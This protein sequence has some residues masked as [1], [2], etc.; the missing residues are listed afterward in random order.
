MPELPEV[1]TIVNALRP[2]AVGRTFAGVRVNDV[3]PLQNLSPEEFCQK[4]IGR[5][6][7]ALDRRGKY[8][9]FRLSGGMNM[10]V[11]L[12]MT[13]ALLWNPAASEPFSRVEYFFD[14]GSLLVF[15]DIRRF[16]TIF[17]VRDASKV[18]G[19][20]GIEPLGNDF[21]A[22]VLKKLLDSRSAPVKSVLLNQEQIA[23]I[24][25]MYADEALFKAKIHPARPASSLHD[26]ELG[27][28]HD[29]IRDVLRRG[30]KNRGASIRDYRAPDGARG[31]AHTEFCVAHRLGEKC[32]RCGTPIKRVVVG[33][34]GTY[35]CP[36][37]QPLRRQHV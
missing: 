13:G 24:G 33:Q 3:R 30:V 5:K 7:I 19:K 18:V 17:L 29:A 16:G 4:L 12:R 6:I 15:S 31:S 9:I 2:H 10:I 20:L 28:L 1:E 22:A 34:R 32:P 11:H 14:D 25:N 21:T 26:S 37:C 8:L 36:I 23:G 27:L 35:F